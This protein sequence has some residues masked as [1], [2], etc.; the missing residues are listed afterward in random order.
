MEQRLKELE[1][2]ITIIKFRN[3][4]VETDKSWETSWM[5]RISIGVMTYLV[6]VLFM[7]SIGVKDPFVNALVPTLGFI[8]STL[9][10]PF[11]KSFW[12]KYI[13]TKETNA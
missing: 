7:N 10:L 11:I 8:L 1:N 3:Q 6:M 4:K 5:R 13:H 12:L 9:S 2:Q